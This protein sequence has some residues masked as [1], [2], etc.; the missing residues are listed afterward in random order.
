MTL[1]EGTVA[2]DGWRKRRGGVQ[3]FEFGETPKIQWSDYGGIRWATDGHGSAGFKI[4]KNIP[5]DLTI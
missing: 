5:E 2:E 4:R 1:G 3:N